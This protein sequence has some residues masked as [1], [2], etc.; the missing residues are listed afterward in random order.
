MSNTGFIFTGI[1]RD[2]IDAS[3]RASNTARR[4]HPNA[5]FTLITDNV[6]PNNPFDRTIVVKR[7][8]HPFFFDRV[9][10]YNRALSASTEHHII[11]MDSDTH[12][13]HP[14]H[15]AIALLNRYDLLAVHAPARY[16]TGSQYN[17]P[18]SFPE[19]NGGVIFVNN[20]PSIHDV[21]NAWEN[22]YRDNLSIYNN[23][24]GPLRD[25]IWATACH[26]L[27]LP[28]EYNF[29]FGFGG[30]VRGRVRILHGRTANFDRVARIVNQSQGM[31]SFHG[32]DFT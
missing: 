24:Q 1:G 11:F 30:Q 2:H 29:R 8:T 31:R 5:T 4:H 12:M 19:L 26:F 22:L 14:V 21:F 9:T 18:P 10:Y 32:S 23:D 20:Q 25:A 7:T 6:P 17:L 27:P 15:D 13:C 16:T 28:C 3:I